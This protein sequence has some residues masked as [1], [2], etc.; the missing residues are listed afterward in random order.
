MIAIAFVDVK[1]GRA[2]C[3][4]FTEQRKVD[5]VSAESGLDANDLAKGI[6][7]GG[8]REI[9]TAT[10]LEANVQSVQRGSSVPVDRP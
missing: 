10:A 8:N 5:R 6:Q 1:K 7:S 2:D 4:K 9:A 3:R